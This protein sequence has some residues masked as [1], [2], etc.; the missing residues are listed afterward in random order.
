[1][2]MRVSRR[3]MEV[4]LLHSAC[5][6]T[7]RLRRALSAERFGAKKE[8]RSRGRRDRRPRWPENPG[9]PC[10]WTGGPGTAYT[11]RHGTPQ[12]ATGSPSHPFAI[13]ARCGSMHSCA[14][15]QPYI[16]GRESRGVET[17]PCPRASY[18]PGS[19]S[20]GCLQARS[21]LH[22]CV[23]YAYCSYR[24]FL[25]CHHLPTLD[26]CGKPTA[27][28]V[29]LRLRAGSRAWGQVRASALYLD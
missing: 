22:D 12:A 20:T 21:C 6:R 15:A 4:F 13:Y 10:A 9:G 29:G 26:G 14:L 27:I 24:T 7:G 19:R 11:H 3:Q 8:F 5:V 18:E 28:R 16:T 2:G 23:L 17:R 25:A 1:M